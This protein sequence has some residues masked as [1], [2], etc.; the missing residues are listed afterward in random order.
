MN[1][2]SKYYLKR[3]KMDT[4][5]FKLYRQTFEKYG[6]TEYNPKT[7]PDGKLEMI[8]Y[9]A[10]IAAIYAPKIEVEFEEGRINIGDSA[11]M[12]WAVNNTKTIIQKDG[13]KKYEKI[14]P[15]LRKN[16]TFMAFVA[17]FSGYELLEKKVIYV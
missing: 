11:M 3:I 6:I 14:E 9:P 8:R 1:E 10:S 17:A 7:N 13:N 5:Q 4:Y 2:V 15:K 16:D 12:R